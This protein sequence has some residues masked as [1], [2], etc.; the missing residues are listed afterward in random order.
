MHALD[1]PI[2]NI[3]IAIGMD[4]LLAV[5][6]DRAWS[7][8]ADVVA[9]LELAI[10]R[11]ERTRYPYGARVDLSRISMR[12]DN[13]ATALKQLRDIKRRIHVRHLDDLRDDIDDVMYLS[14]G[15]ALNPQFFNDELRQAFSI[16]DAEGAELLYEAPELLV[17]PD[18]IV[19]VSDALLVMLAKSPRFLYE[20][21]PRRFEEVI[22]ELFRKEGF[23]VELTRATRDDGVDIIAISRRMNI[24]H[25]MVVEC[26]RYAPDNRVGI[27]VVQRLLGVKA[28]TSA[29]KAVVVTTSSFSRDA[30]RVARERFWDLD[31]KAYS[32]VVS[33]LQNAA[34][35]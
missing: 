21:S 6:R 29:N 22:A 10:E 5:S 32:D 35:V 25:K 7:Q 23:D 30:Q 1:S 31:L 11:H 16:L 34:S 4:P 14:R 20:I 18:L 26:K 13:L 28:Q 27:S 33:W 24:L 17:A 3:S 2:E 19:P 15:V 8:L 12:R 9:E